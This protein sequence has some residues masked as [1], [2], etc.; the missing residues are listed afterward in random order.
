MG[1]SKSRM[2]SR[3]S[4]F[5]LQTHVTLCLLIYSLDCT[6]AKSKISSNSFLVDRETE[7]PLP[8]QRI[9]LI[10]KRERW[11]HSLSS[12]LRF[13]FS[14]PA[15]TLRAIHPKVFLSDTEILAALSALGLAGDGDFHGGRPVHSQVLLKEDEQGSHTVGYHT[16][17]P[18]RQRA[19]P[20]VPRSY[21]SYSSCG[22]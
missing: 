11:S 18:G 7:T 3:S 13:H 20:F 15:L 10:K 2:K 19:G 17:R 22:K 1:K 12:H 16:R 21:C 5:N 14:S 6:K 8:N 9:S 4:F